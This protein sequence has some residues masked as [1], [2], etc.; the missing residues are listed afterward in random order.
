MLSW[1]LL[2]RI[3]LNIFKYKSHLIFRKK[4]LILIL[5][6]ILSMKLAYR[7]MKLGKPDNLIP[8]TKIT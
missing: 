8:I 2:L 6:K 5:L 3:K 7:S 1:T 4:Y